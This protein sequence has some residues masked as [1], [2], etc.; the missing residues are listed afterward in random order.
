MQ[1]SINLA[2]H[3]FLGKIILAWTVPFL[4][5]GFCLKIALNIELSL[6]KARYFATFLL[7]PL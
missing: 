6:K 5:S 3:L 1:T 7:Q 2:I 4:V